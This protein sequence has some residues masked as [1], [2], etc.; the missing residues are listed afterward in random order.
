MEHCI[1]SHTDQGQ[2]PAIVH[3]I[4]RNQHHNLANWSLQNFLTPVASV[5]PMP[6]AALMILNLRQVVSSFRI[7]A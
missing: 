1:T 5:R 7:S 2:H 3:S 6:A 4:T